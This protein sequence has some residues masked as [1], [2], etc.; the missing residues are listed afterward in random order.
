M[1]MLSAIMTRLG[2]EA[3]KVLDYMNAIG[4]TRRGMRQRKAKREKRTDKHPL[5]AYHFGNF[6][7]LK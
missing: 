6:R 7:P 3:N 5:H 1:N 2:M 4:P